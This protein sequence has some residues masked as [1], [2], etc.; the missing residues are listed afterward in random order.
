MGMLRVVLLCC[1]AGLL[2][3]LS[4]Q[5]EFP[6]P[7]G[8]E[9]V[10]EL[11]R[12]RHLVPA[13]LIARE[14]LQKAKEELAAAVTEAEKTELEEQ[15]NT[16]RQRLD[17]LRNNFRSLA[18]GVDEERFLGVAEEAATLEGTV[19]D[20]LSPIADFFEDL[21]KEPREIGEL[22]NRLESARA[23]S[24]LARDAVGRIDELLAEAENEDI[25][26]E[27]QVTRELW[28]GRSERASSE[29]EVYDQQIE[30]RNRDKRPFLEKLSDGFAGFWRSR[31]LNLVLAMLAAFLAGFGVLKGYWLMRRM[32]PFRGKGG[33][34]SRTSDLIAKVLTGVAAV[35]AAVLVFYLRGDWLML[36]LSIVVILGVLWASKEA[37][38][39]YI[40]QIRLILNLGSVREGERLIYHGVPW[41]VERLNFFCRFKNPELS[42][43]VLRVP[44]QEVMGM[45][46][47]QHDPREPW[48][49][50]QE[51]DWVILSDETYGKVVE[52]TPDQVVVLRLGGSR[53]TYATTDF[54]ALSP[55]NLSRGFR[56]SVTFG[57]DYDHQPIS[58]GEVPTVFRVALE[59]VLNERF[60]H[61][62]VRSVKVEFASAGASSL[63]YAVLADFD[64]E[65]ASRR[66]VIERLIQATCVEVCNERDWVIPFT[67]VT[68]HQ[69]AND[70]AVAGS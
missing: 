17:E 33:L 38:P 45:Q 1:W 31:G 52:Q 7:A 20:L 34:A 41:K 35:V 11:E 9:E 53:K 57:I 5:E 65:V 59:R 29:A 27:L 26:E 15:V 60:G 42:G 8:V 46:S 12:L 64:G 47:R 4:A 30:L 51:N 16:Q 69:A 18:S 43:G 54:L 61:E 19:R 10:R 39:P 44:I 66:N 67:Q 14:D 22:E 23:R 3:G 36:A 48:F 40:E 56:V 28:Q 6:S 68:V 63:D 32:K 25:R 37:I 50:T 49:P 13:L 2:S 58:I 55:E 62:Q 21:T 24:E 70:G